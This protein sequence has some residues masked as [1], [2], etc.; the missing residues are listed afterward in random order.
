MR[1]ITTTT[2][3]NIP[4]PTVA[5][6]N[7]Q[8]A[9][10]QLG[11]F[12]RAHAALEV[13]L[14]DEYET[15]CEELPTPAMRYLARL[16]LADEQRH[17]VIFGDLAETVFATDELKALGMPILESSHITDDAVR[18]RTLGMLGHV[19]AREGEER[20]RLATLIGLL[21]QGEPSELW[22]VLLELVAQDTQ[23]H[24]SLLEFMRTRML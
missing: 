19:I 8:H 24:L 23:Q 6:E 4:E 14:L 9:A 5:V 21:P 7:R 2:H 15:L 12:L 16:I 22:S 13:E 17:Q 10:R 1:S 11:D 3:A 20:S 18:Q